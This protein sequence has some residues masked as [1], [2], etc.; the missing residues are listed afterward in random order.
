M[1][2][3]SPRRDRYLDAMGIQRWR[4]RGREVEQP[5]SIVEDPAATDSALPTEVATDWQ[6]LQQQVAG[7]R[8][9]GELVSNRTQTVF[10]VGN[11]DA[12]WMVIGEAPGADEDRQGEPFVGVAGQLLNAMLAAINLPRESIYIANTL[13]CRPPG[14]RNPTTEE[15][16]QCRPYLDRQIELVAPR[17]ILAVGRIAV[18]NLLGTEES[19]SKLRGRVHR[20]GDQQIPVIVT[21]HPAYLLRNPIDK[22]KAWEDLKLAVRVMQGGE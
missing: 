8:A 17:L 19:I 9:C 21:Y 11:A 2:S 3:L 20:L 22:R 5:D 15:A 12:D 18:H 14:N 6:G 1:G 10:G 7:C 4:L 13:K 16:Q